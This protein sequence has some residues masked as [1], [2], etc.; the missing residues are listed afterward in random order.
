[1]ATIHKTDHQLYHLDLTALYQTKNLLT[2]LETIS[3]LQRKGW[4]IEDS[5]LKK[6]LHQVKKLTGLHGRWEI[7]HNRPLI[8]LDVAHNEDGVKELVKQIEITDHTNLHII[9]G[10][11]KDKEVET[12][13]ELF[14]DSAEYYFTQAHIPRALDAEILRQKAARFN[15][16]GKSFDDVNTALHDAFN[17]AGQEDM[18]LI[19]GSVFLIGEVNDDLPVHQ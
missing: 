17:N 18:I 11:V 2:V 12:I 13:L 9:L 14:P 10:I 3:Q 6:S 1:V 15:L 19:C 7:I 4:V 5:I 8:V 16:N